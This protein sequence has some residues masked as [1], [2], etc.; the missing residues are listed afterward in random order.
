M[1]SADLG[2]WELA[3]ESDSFRVGYLDA[4]RGVWAGWWQLQRR[5]LTDAEL[6]EYWR[7]HNRG[8]DRK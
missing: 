8:K 1:A 5:G 3:R 4:V 2:P 6:S 7:G